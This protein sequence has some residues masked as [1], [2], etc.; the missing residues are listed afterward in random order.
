M[1]RYTL[2]ALPGPSGA[3]RTGGVNDKANIA[4][5]ASDRGKA[6]W[7]DSDGR[8]HILPMVVD[9]SF[10]SDINDHGIIAG[11]QPSSTSSGSAVPRAFIFHDGTLVDIANQLPGAESSANVVNNDGLVGGRTGDDYPT[12]R[13]FLYNHP[14]GSM[15]L[16]DPLPGH[17]RGEV[18]A[19]NKAGHVAGVSFSSDPTDLGTGV[20]W[21]DGQLLNTGPNTMLFDINDSDVAVGARFDEGRERWIACRVD[22]GTGAA[23]L[24]DLTAEPSYGAAINNDGVVVGWIQGPPPDY[25]GN[26]P[27]AFVCYPPGHPEAGFHRLFQRLNGAVSWETTLATDINDSGVIVGH[28]EPGPVGP[29]T[30]SSYQAFAAY[31]DPLLPHLDFVHWTSANP[32]GAVGTLHGAQVTLSGPMGTAFYLHD[33]YPN[34]GTTSFTP[35]L[36]A[37]G[38][39]EIVGGTDHA[40]TLSFG[41]AQ[42][43]PIMHLGSLASVLTFPPGT[44]V[45]R[46]SGDADFVANG[47]V[48]TG[49]LA[50]PVVTGDTLGPSDSNGSIRLNGTFSTITF[51]LVPNFADGSIPDGVFLQVG[52]A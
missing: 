28:G 39:V 30:S 36:N 27:E 38:M 51:T 26:R 24:E 20:L 8:L 5:S 40:F 11:N 32:N 43:D 14:T 48:V 31:P 21:R 19:I 37:T 2:D 9:G 34:F 12:R 41:A 13:P 25:G 35:R 1:Q 29:G 4:G 44:T 42:Q 18:F 33:D 6:A 46:L 15:T 45:T 50:N 17:D 52:A 10:A 16:L 49:K 3:L 7:W 23:V 47:N 22:F